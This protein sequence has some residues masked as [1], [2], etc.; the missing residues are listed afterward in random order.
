MR[1]GLISGRE[2]VNTLAFPKRFSSA[3]LIYEDGWS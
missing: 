2:L 1:S 3:T